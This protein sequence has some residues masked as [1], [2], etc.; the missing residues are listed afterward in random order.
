MIFVASPD[1]VIEQIMIQCWLFEARAGDYAGARTRAERTLERLLSAGLPFVRGASGLL[2]D[3]YAANNRLKSRVGEP[4][5]EAWPDWQRT[6]RRNAVSL[7][8]TPH[9]YR[10]VLQREWHAYITTPKRP[11]TVRLPL[12]LRQSQRG[13]A[14]VRLLEPAGA[15]LDMRE[16]HGRVEL[17]L[18]SAAIRGPIV[19]ELEVQFVSGEVLDPLT[20]SAPLGAPVE[21]E[22]L[23]WL[24]DREELIAPSPAVSLLAAELA[25]PCASAREFAHAAW[26]WMISNLRFGDVHRE[27]L[28]PGDP[29]GGLLRTRLVDCVLGSSL[30]VALC[31]ARGIPA[32]VVSG[33]LLH[34]ANVGPHAWAEVRLGRDLWIPFDIGSW[35]YSAGDPRDPAWGGFFRGTVDA[36]FLAEVAPR[37]FTGYGSARPPDRWYRLERLQGG[38]M[39]HTLHALPEGTLYRRDLLDLQ[40][41]GAAG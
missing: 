22:D 38:R 32:R 30:L 37:E 31:R 16:S 7:P 35:C 4:A 9:R 36:R 33:F 2:L 10:F 19:A 1:D 11:V 41:L 23:I 15:L 27:H 5:D 14:Q 29:L 6:T 20:P 34:P 18:D 17:R 40:I 39:Q 21:P 25:R 24:R 3:P 13:A 8:K 26:H 28:H 12:P